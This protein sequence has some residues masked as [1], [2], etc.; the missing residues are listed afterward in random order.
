MVAMR[1]ALE[2]ESNQLTTISTRPIQARALSGTVA[3]ALALLFV[4]AALGAAY[5]LLQ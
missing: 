5:L 2:S 3:M 1:K 4:L